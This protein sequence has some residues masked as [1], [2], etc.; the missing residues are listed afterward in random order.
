MKRGLLALAICMAPL[1]A[2]ATNIATIVESA[3]AV[4]ETY[5]ALVVDAELADLRY[6]K[7]RIEATDRIQELAADSTWLTAR[8]AERRSRQTFYGEVVDALYGAVTADYDRIVAERND[9]IA[10]D[11][12]AV[13]AVQFRNG[14]VPESDLFDARI[15]VRSAAIDREEK[16]WLLTDALTTLQDATGLEFD[17]VSLPATPSFSMR[18]SLDQW[19]ERDPS[20]ALA[21]VA[22]EIARLRVERMPANVARFDRITLETEL[23]RARLAT[24]R[25]LN[26]SE[27]TYEAFRRRLTT[28]PELIVIRAEQ[29][30]ISEA[31]YR[32][33]GERFDRGLITAV[34]REQT[35]V[36]VLSARR[37]LVEAERTY[38]KTIVE[39]A[40][41]A[42]IP[43]EEVL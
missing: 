27:R 35:W 12:E 7:N 20:V 16:S 9:E 42:G 43:L 13:V 25:A 21:R 5:R 1:V 15:A 39:Y 3:E 40:A 8:A 4:N 37:N 23:E 2:H 41:A 14:L 10:R 32:E 6:E 28:L 18:L 22:E 33:A 11:R 38:V 19:L 30:Q 36:R 34:Q 29:L 31:S 17:N 26:S 24:E